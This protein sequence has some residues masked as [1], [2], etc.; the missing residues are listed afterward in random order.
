MPKAYLEHEGSEKN[1]SIP[2][3]VN[4]SY[5]YYKDATVL[6]ENAIVSQKKLYLKGRKSIGKAGAPF[7]VPFEKEGRFL[8]PKKERQEKKGNLVRK[9]KIHTHIVLA[10]PV[11]PSP[12]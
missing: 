1:I 2:Q 8:L 7:R 11:N 10:L 5:V 3:S 12:T 4:A 9:S 6:P